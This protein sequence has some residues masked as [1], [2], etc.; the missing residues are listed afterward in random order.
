MDF[1]EVWEQK[2]FTHEFFVRN[3]TSA[4]FPVNFGVSCDCLDVEPHTLKLTSGESRPIRVSF[5]LTSRQGHQ[6]GMPLREVRYA[7]RPYRAD[8]PNGD[9]GPAFV[10]SGRVRSRVTLDTLRADFADMLIAGQSNEPLR[11][12]AALHVPADRVEADVAA[13][14]LFRAE[15]VRT[16]D[17]PTFAILLHPAPDMPPGKFRTELVVTVVVG[18]ARTAAGWLPVVGDVQPEVRPLPARVWLGSKPVGDTLETVVALQR[19]GPA[20]RRA[21]V[22]RVETDAAHVAVDPTP[23][24][25]GTGALAYRVRVRVSGPGDHSETIRFVVRRHGRGPET[26]TTELNYRGEPPTAA[27]HVQP[28]GGQP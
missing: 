14:H 25:L 1:G 21:V 26:V 13:P 11:I 10:L 27:A 7:I 17:G 15:I 8:Q 9:T 16:G 4:A 20:D 24:P 23:E 19:P 2:S 28:N 12:A 22:E 6:R 3:N 18:G 5:D